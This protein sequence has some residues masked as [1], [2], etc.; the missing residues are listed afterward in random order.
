MI[1]GVHMRFCFVLCWLYP[2]QS[3]WKVMVFIYRTLTK[4]EQNLRFL[5]ALP[6]R[7]PH[8]FNTPSLQFLEELLT[9][10][11]YE[12]YK[13]ALKTVGVYLPTKKTG[14]FLPE[15]F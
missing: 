11:M 13:P 8:S 1:L 14:S 7:E 6:G 10:E 15:K 4:D 5:F 9:V 12:T 3:Q 2:C